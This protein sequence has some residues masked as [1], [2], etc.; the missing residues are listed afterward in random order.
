MDKWSSKWY[1]VA[2]LIILG[3]LGYILWYL[4]LNPRYVLVFLATTIIA[5]GFVAVMALLPKY[6][7]QLVK[8][9][10]EYRVKEREMGRALYRYYKVAL[11]IIIVCALFFPV[12]F[13]SQ[14]IAS[15]HMPL[16]VL[17]FFIVNLV[18]GI[19]FIAG[20]LKARG[21]WGLL[22]IAVIFTSVLLGILIGWLTKHG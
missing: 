22:L 5:L 17:T 15:Q 2:I 7:L 3:M 18:A 21:K 20:F 9:M 10:L 16:F 8:K 14:L 6:R 19:I 1:W 4:S 12:V 11:V 13:Q